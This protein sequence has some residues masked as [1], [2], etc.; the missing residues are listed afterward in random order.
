MI[1][2]E[3]KDIIRSARELL[4]GRF[5]GVLATHSL[6]CAGYPFGSLLP[7]SLGRDGWPLIL[8]S[9]LAKHTRNLSLDPHCCLTVTEQQLGDTQTLARLSCLA[10]AIPVGD[11]YSPAAD[12][13]F[14]YFPESRNYFQELNF[15][16]YR[17]EP[18]RFYCVA[19]FGAARWVGVDRMKAVNPFSYNEEETLLTEINSRFG[20]RLNERLGPRVDPQSELP[21]VGLDATGID[22]RQND[23]IFRLELPAAVNS[24]P[25]LLSLLADWI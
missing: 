2:D 18:V 4:S 25:G 11:I 24:P 10:D 5:Q 21:A 6:D 7:Y 15:L 1:K 20:G 14:R 17:L 3:E 19:G 22:L 12:R 13:H 9:H 8:I 16:F 23:K